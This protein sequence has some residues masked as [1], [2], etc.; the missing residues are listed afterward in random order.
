M[1]EVKL[2]HREYCWMF[3]MSIFQ[4]DEDKSN[5]D[6]TLRIGENNGNVVI[7][8]TC[9]VHG[10]K[11]KAMA[12]TRFCHMHILSDSMQKLYKD[13]SFAI[14][15]EKD[16]YEVV[17]KVGRGKYSEV[18]EGIHTTNNENA[19]SKSLSQ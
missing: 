7:S 11:S 12:L 3:G 17:R 13:C 2:N 1:E 14:K 19:S 15:R 16:D 10:C 18:F 4:E 8:N 5:K 6:G 9:G